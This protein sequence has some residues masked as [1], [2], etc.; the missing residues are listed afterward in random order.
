MSYKQNGYNEIPHVENFVVLSTAFF[1]ILSGN[2]LSGNILSGNILS[3][4]ILSG[5]TIILF[6]L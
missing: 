4:N 6:L 2:I 3:G 5:N 1:I